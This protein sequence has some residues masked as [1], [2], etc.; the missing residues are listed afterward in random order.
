MGFGDVKIMLTLGA[1]LGW[2]GALFSIAAGSVI[3]AVAG[4]LLLFT[5]RLEAAGRIP[6]GPYLAVGALL[7]IAAGPAVVGWLWLR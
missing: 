6:F 3:G 7:W 1:F 4:V 2:P 5:G